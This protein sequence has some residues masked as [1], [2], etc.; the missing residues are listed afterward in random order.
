MLA[1]HHYWKIGIVFRIVFPSFHVMWKWFSYSLETKKSII[2]S[3]FNMQSW[4][5][6]IIC[7]MSRSCLFD[8]FL[9]DI[10]QRKF[11][12][13]N[14]K[15]DNQGAIALVKNPVRHRKSKNIDIKYHF[16]CDYHESNKT[17]GFWNLCIYTPLKVLFW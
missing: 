12:P 5:Y 11:L 13:V 9:K 1:G 3:S 6:G 10:A 16:I 14:I 15:N 8:T 4:V 17:Q 2:S 7:C